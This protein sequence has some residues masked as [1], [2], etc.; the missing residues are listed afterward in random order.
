MQR[1]CR[2]YDNAFS[3]S[4]CDTGSGSRLNEILQRARLSGWRATL[5]TPGC[6]HDKIRLQ[7]DPSRA[8]VSLASHSFQK[9]LS[10][11][12]PEGLG[13]LIDDSQKWRQDGNVLNVIEAHEAHVPRNHRLLT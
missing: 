7:D 3:I 2:Y 1:T 10:A 9:Q 8:H 4:F 13:G 6:P 11:E 5:H 12:A